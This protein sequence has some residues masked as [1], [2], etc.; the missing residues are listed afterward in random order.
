MR[1]CKK[2]VQPDTRP[3]IVFD[4]ESV[5]FA[6]RY[7]EN[8]DKINW[9]SRQNE[10]KEIVEY[11]KKNNH[12]SYDC[13]IGVSGGKDSTFQAIYAR[14]MLGLNPLLVNAVPEG[15]TEIG[16][17]NINNLANLGFDLFMIRPNPNVMRKLIKRDFYKYCNPQK[18]TEYTLWASTYQVALAY[19]IPLIIQ[20]EN[21][22]LTLGVAKGIGKDGDATNVFKSNTLSGGDAFG[23]YGDVVDKK[24][25]MQYQF[26][27]R[28]LFG[29]AGIKAIWLQYYF[30]EWNCRH[31]AEFSM[32][33]GLKIRES[34]NF[35]ELGR[36]TNF[37]A[38]DSDMNIYNQMLKY[39]KFGFGAATDEACYDIRNG[40]I[41][42]E[43]AIKLVKQYDGK[44][45]EK[46]II[47]FCDYIDIPVEEFWRVTD[48]FVNKKLFTKD[49]TTGKWKPKFEVGIDFDEQ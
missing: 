13:V 19:K 11:A 41:T 40:R 28:K 16:K 48:G 22:G 25:L 37:G 23:E 29:L 24:S 35:D 3:G 8:R 2:C 47:G 32:A 46:Y 5:C 9:I 49:P 33:R 31:N 26:P 14:D 42:R 27:D 44:C 38:L 43:A 39:Y 36:Y 7:A 20:G 4:K 1:Y 12:G 15:V 34:A 6:C 18:V 17:Y 21:A 45:G 10:L 30:K